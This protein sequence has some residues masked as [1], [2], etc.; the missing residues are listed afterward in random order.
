MAGGGAPRH[1]CGV[2][3]SPRASDAGRGG[4]PPRRI[5]VAALLLLLAA[6]AATHGVMRW[7]A[8][9]APATAADG[10]DQLA[11]TLDRLLQ[12]G[13]DASPGVALRPLAAA[14]AAADDAVLAASVCAAVA[15]R[16][17]RLPSLRVVPCQSTASAVAADLDDRRLARLL[18]V[19]Y[20]IKG[21][22]QPL[23]GERL[24][25]KLA[26]HEAGSGA[27]PAW[28]IDEALPRGELQSL[29]ARVAEATGLALGQG[30]AG[31]PE[32]TIAPE[33]Y[34]QY[35][36][37]AELARRVSIDD[38]R[39]AITLLEEVLAAEPGHVPSLYLRQMVRGS[40]LGNLGPGARA[41]ST[42][43]L[44]AERAANVQAGLDL[45]RRLVAADAGD[46]R[47]QYLLLANEMEVKRWPDG[48]AR[49]DRMVQHHPRHPGLLRL[50]ARM[51]LHA[52]YLTRAH[53]LALAAAQING[54]DAE[55]VEILAA[56]AGIRGDDGQLRELIA[57]ARQLG[58]QGIGRIEIFEA[59]RRADWAALERSLAGYVGWG[60]KWSAAWV[61]DYVKGLDDPSARPA[62]VAL[63]D[64]HDAATRQHFASYHV[65][66]ALLGDAER[67]LRSVQ[68]HA[69]RPPASWMQ[70]LWWP[71]MAAVRRQPG[72]VPAMREL[73]M[74]ALWDVR[75]A[76]DLCRRDGA[77]WVC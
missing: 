25:L 58:H 68:H 72:F 64:G 71:E 53:E 74:A 45:A 4:P 18:A 27:A 29:P 26:L 16:L 34:A 21:S 67:S 35:L 30:V 43:E 56:V 37:A 7:L 9:P 48:F 6:A 28:Q 57:V 40:I 77:E 69:R 8:A 19:R 13:A 47:G 14:S 59:M 31:P 17:A 11:T 33:R 63:L 65:E 20:V 3:D 32:P 60:G 66:Y 75:G 22:L 52:G 23:A 1:P 44:D 61:P 39:S 41:A 38:R 62:A 12:R 15:E 10:A 50:A 46:M 73:G 5:V 24:H 49:L 54:L 76:P 55:A 2:I 42:A 36:R 51:H 70:H